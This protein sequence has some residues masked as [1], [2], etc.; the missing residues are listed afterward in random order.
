MITPKEVE[1]F[2]ED[3][4][5]IFPPDRYVPTDGYV[6]GKVNKALV[7]KMQKWVKENNSYTKETIFAA[8][9]MYVLSKKP[10]NFAYMKRPIYFIMKQG[11][12]SMLEA[13][14][15]K[16]LAGEKIS[17][18]NEYNPVDEFI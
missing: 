11:E 17:E 2:M 15:D 1:G 12:D 3:W 7:N 8:T 14:C 9:R 10:V 6:R 18:H 13:F 5:K 16:V 4:L